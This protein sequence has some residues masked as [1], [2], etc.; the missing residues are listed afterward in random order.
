MVL[1][2]CAHCFKLFQR[3]TDYTRHVD[4]H[5]RQAVKHEEEQLLLQQSERELKPFICDMCG[6]DF[7]NKYTLN[8]H[9][10]FSGKFIN[11]NLLT[12]IR[13]GKMN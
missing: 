3:K 2:T 9:K 6:N 8:Y 10:N 5:K 13:T 12:N 7:I 4:M 11:E 1:Y